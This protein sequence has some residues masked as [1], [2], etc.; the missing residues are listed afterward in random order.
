MHEQ[1]I[2]LSLPVQAPFDFQA[3]AY[4]HGWAVL[5][6]NV[7]RDAEKTLETVVRLPTGP[8]VR[9]SIKSGGRPAAP[10]IQIHVLAPGPI[11]TVAR[12]EIKRVVRRMFRVDEDL[13]G[14]Y[15]ISKKRG[16][17]WNRLLNGAGRLLRSASLFEDIVKTICTTNI[18]WA[19]T[20]SMVTNLVTR[21]GDPYPAAPD[22]RAF[23]DAEALAAAP[24]TELTQARLGYRA[25][26][27][28]EL[29]KNVASGVLNLG[30][31]EDP[32]LPLAELRQRLLSIK[33]IGN[34]AAGTLLMLLGHYEHLAF[35]TLMRDFV[36][37]K[38]LDGRQPVEA[39]ALAVY[40]DW[41]KWRFLA[42]WFDLLSD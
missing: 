20:K 4:S 15:K 30:D 17:P 14:F 25:G 35:D 8:V 5:A 9:L 12:K 41:G 38:Y 13:S 3:T 36:A 22:F 7:W 18:Q 40:K 10:R 28:S 29:A 42:Y 2:R 27:V 11:E 19:G 37:E 6:P 23:P 1:R 32:A 24:I 16:A 34:Y 31:L 33:G 26:Y 21:F 39:E